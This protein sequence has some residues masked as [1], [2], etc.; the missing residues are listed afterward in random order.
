MVWRESRTPFLVIALLVFLNCWFCLDRVYSLIREN[1]QNA[2]DVA[3]VDIFAGTYRIWGIMISYLGAGCLHW[4]DRHGGRDFTMSLPLCGFHMNLIRGLV[5][6]FHVTMLVIV[7]GALAIRLHG[8]LRPDFSV[9]FAPNMALYG[10]GAGV[11]IYGISMLGAVVVRNLYLA[12]AFAWVNFISLNFV[13]RW[14]PGMRL[15][16][17]LNGLVHLGSPD[18]PPM[19][20]GPLVLH[21]GLGLTA[22]AV[23]AYASV[24]RRGPG[25]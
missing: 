3:M 17:A 12:S 5:G 2:N 9:P 25:I 14:L 4:E 20:W 18:K 1:R 22:I 7:P 10:I 15:Y 11:M 8:F 13:F 19:L 6:L 24:R 23:A 16:S 21:L